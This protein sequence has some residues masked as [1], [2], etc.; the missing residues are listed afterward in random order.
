MSK[1]FSQGIFG[2]FWGSLRA[3][4]R[5]AMNTLNGNV[6][7]KKNLLHTAISCTDGIFIV[8]LYFVLL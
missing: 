1:I 3:G 4:T 7:A 5:V 6:F 2:P 8:N